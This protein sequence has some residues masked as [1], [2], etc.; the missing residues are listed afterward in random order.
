MVGRRVRVRSA[1]RVRVRRERGEG[2][3]GRRARAPVRYHCA[4]LVRAGGIFHRPFGSLETDQP[5]WFTEAEAERF[6]DSAVELRLAAEA[7]AGAGAVG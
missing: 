7:A 4:V 2:T 3:V 5:R 6:T 1:S